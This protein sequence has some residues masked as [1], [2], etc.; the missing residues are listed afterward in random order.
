MNAC[1]HL[2]HSQTT[3]RVDE[4]APS[5]EPWQARRSLRASCRSSAGECIHY[6]SCEALSLPPPRTPPA[7][8]MM[9]SHPASCGA[10]ERTANSLMTLQCRREASTFHREALKNVA[11][12]PLAGPLPQPRPG[13]SLSR[14]PCLNSPAR[15]GIR[16]CMAETEQLHLHHVPRPLPPIHS[17]AAAHDTASSVHSMLFTAQPLHWPPPVADARGET[18]DVPPPEDWHRHPG[19]LS[20]YALCMLCKSTSGCICAAK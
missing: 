12:P 19:L 9:A 17:T 6:A 7:F 13:A 15:G 2:A 10:A 18:G 20:G 4:P 5:L 16:P 1:S 3:T 14:A 11:S 8:S